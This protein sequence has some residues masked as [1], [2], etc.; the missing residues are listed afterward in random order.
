MGKIIKN[1]ISDLEKVIIGVYLGGRNPYK[2][3]STYVKENQEKC[4]DT[5]EWL[6]AWLQNALSARRYSAALEICN[7]ICAG[8]DIMVG[9]F[10]I[11]KY[12][13][14]R[15]TYSF[16][17]AEIAMFGI[18][19]EKGK[20]AAISLLEVAHSYVCDYIRFSGLTTEKAE[21]DAEMFEGM[22]ECSGVIR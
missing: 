7:W 10:G 21:K 2:W 9:A 13:G 15:Y 18:G 4:R 8:T 19:G 20:D 16:L 22:I 3:N 14:M 11:Q 1:L 6:T 5:L 17:L 12:G